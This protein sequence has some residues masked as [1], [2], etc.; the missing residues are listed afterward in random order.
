MGHAGFA[1]SL[2]IDISPLTRYREPLSLASYQ[3]KT[4]LSD[5]AG[6]LIPTFPDERH[7]STTLRKA[8]YAERDRSRAMDPGTLDFIAGDRE[9]VRED[10]GNEEPDRTDVADE[11]RGRQRAL[12]ILEARSK[13]PEAGM[14]MSLA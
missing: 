5:R 1:A 6:T 11:G 8:S 3:P 14:W 4:S 13:I 10:E 7:T 2:P 12:K 9:E